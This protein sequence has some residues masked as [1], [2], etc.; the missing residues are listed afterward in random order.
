MPGAIIGVRSTIEDHTI[1]NT[2]AS[3]D[4]DCHIGSFSHIG[5]GA[6]IGGTVLVGENTLVGL[7]SSV[8]NNL[9]VGSRV[10]IPA[11]FAVYKDIEDGEVLSPKLGKIWK[12]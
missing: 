10:R 12:Y 6:H 7:G 5:P 11:G 8:V 4:H 9:K 3:V 2:C 1:I